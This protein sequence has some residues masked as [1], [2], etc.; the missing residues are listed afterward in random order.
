MFLEITQQNLLGVVRFVAVF[1][2]TQKDA[3]EV[4]SP[5][6]VVGLFH[7]NH[8]TQILAQRPEGPIG[9]PTGNNVDVLSVNA[10]FRQLT[11]RALFQTRKLCLDLLTK[12][13][14]GGRN[15]SLL[16]VFRGNLSLAQT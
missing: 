5:L 3:I 11:E 4:Q 6:A 10:M 9:T 14:V 1:A 7:L 13:G 2:V 12:V 15:G 16:Q 8:W